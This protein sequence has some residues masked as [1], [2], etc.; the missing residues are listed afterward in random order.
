[1]AAMV[2]LRGAAGCASHRFLYA[3]PAAAKRGA[4]STAGGAAPSK[5]GKDSGEEAGEKPARK[6]RTAKKEDMPSPPPE[7][8]RNFMDLVAG[9]PKDPKRW[10]AVSSWVVFSDL[11]VSSATLDTC[12]DTL[13][14]VKSEAASRGAGVL[15]LGD[16]WH[17]RG[18][19]PVE[20]L[21][22][23]LEELKDWTA[24]TLMLVGNHDQVTAG[25]MVHALEPLAA[26][27]PSIHVFDRPTRF[28]DAL[29]LPYR[30]DPSL[31][32]DAVEAA[33]SV[34][35]IF[36]HV[37]I[38]GAYM[39]ETFQA[40][41]GLP[42]TLFPPHI[43]TYT[44]HYHRRHTVEGTNIHYVGSSY[45]VSRSEA[46][47]AKALTLLDSSWRPVEEIPVDLGPRFF[48]LRPSDIKGAD[49]LEGRGPLLPEELR[50]GDRVRILLNSQQAD[51]EEA[52]VIEDVIRR[53]AKLE[54]MSAPAAAQARISA[55]EELGALPLF[56][57]YADSVGLEEGAVA[58]S[59]EILQELQSA[60]ATVTPLTR[61]VELHSLEIEG[62]G[63]FC[64]PA[65]YQLKDKGLQVVV[66]R[67]LDDAGADSNGAGKT[68]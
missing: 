20:P 4:S 52:A 40:R 60:G 26:A 11:H 29:W 35:A 45:Q 1:M 57:R 28:M 54:T 18:S 39:N 50:Q 64:G 2:R 22:A 43:P 68:A 41:E 34:N 21:N 24:P 66:G 67:N 9:V 46:G 36:A 25:G 6:K 56:H 47:Q 49:G 44:G 12:L 63:P 59:I 7:E 51:E 65:S 10:Q 27:A 3:T 58:A 13:R 37:D 38:V 42:P 33:G 61:E 14:L 19:L 30:R 31:L 16:F 62:F 48:L 8:G 23:V 17:H 55:A 53:G 15:F 5:K 32:A